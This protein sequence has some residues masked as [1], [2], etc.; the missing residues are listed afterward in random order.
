MNSTTIYLKKTVVYKGKN[1]EV[2][3]ADKKDKEIFMQQI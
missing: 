2:N 3:F 1:V